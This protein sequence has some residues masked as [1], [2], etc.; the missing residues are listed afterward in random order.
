MVLCPVQLNFF[1][2][3]IVIFSCAVKLFNL[4]TFTYSVNTIPTPA[5]KL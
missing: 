5:Y 3:D 2:F 4:A 1:I